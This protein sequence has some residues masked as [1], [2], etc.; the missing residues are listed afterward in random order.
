MALTVSDVLLQGPALAEELGRD[1]VLVV[2]RGGPAVSTEVDPGIA[3]R[4]VL[5]GTVNERKSSVLDTSV[6]VVGQT[7]GGRTTLAL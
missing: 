1:A 5:R 6:T 3:R 2:V 7:V 4:L